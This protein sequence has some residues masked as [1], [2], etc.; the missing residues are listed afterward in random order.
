MV[1]GWSLTEMYSIYRCGWNI[2]TYKRKIE[3]PVQEKQET[4][5]TQDEEKQNKDKDTTQYTHSLFLSMFN[6][7]LVSIGK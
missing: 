1:S 3:G 5:V 6:Y 4:Q 2:A 7:L